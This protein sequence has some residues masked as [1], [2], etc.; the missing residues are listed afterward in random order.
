MQTPPL[1]LENYF[2]PVVQVMANPAFSP[3]A[4]EKKGPP[5]LN[6]SLAMTAEE[7]IYQV[8][9][10]LA[11]EG[12]EENPSQYNIA[13]QA[14]G[15]FAVEPEFADNENAVKAA[16]AGLLY[17]ASREFLLSIMARGPW[18]PIMLHLMFFSPKMFEQQA[19][20][21]KPRT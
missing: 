7:N 4:A 17:T 6:W 11:V 10:N 14:V 21:E 5:L 13:L 12:T 9:L 20:A 15:I 3:D 18:T 19:T 1:R 2:F 8:H 16:A